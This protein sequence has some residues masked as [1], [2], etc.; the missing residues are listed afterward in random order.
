VVAKEPVFSKV[1]PAVL[2]FFQSER[3]AL[4][5]AGVTNIASPMKNISILL[6]PFLFLACAK[7][8]D[9]NRSQVAAVPPAQYEQP[10]QQNQPGRP[11]YGYEYPGQNCT[12]GPQRFVNRDLYCAALRSDRRNNHCALQYRYEDFRRNCVGRRWQR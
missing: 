4:S 6:I 1:A 12:T 7:G 5:F 3:R 11:P 10:Q 8:S 9:D 2:V